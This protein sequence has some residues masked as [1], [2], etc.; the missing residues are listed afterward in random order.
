MLRRV[1]WVVERQRM[2]ELVQAI[3]VVGGTVGARSEIDRFPED[4][5]AFGD[6]DGEL[7][8]IV[9]VTV[10]EA[11]L[12]QLVAQAIRRQRAGQLLIV[13]LT[14]PCLQLRELALPVGGG[15]IFRSATGVCAFDAKGARLA[16]RLIGAVL[17]RAATGGGRGAGLIPSPSA[18]AGIYLSRSPGVEP[19]PALAR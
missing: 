14:Q 9:E 17:R 2:G 4:L 19:H 11:S 16:L 7:L 12:V 18:D 10:P 15:V 5:D 8:S 1:Q 13:D 6:S 3:G